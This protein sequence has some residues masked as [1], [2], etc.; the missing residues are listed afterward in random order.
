MESPL[1]AML[2]V[3]DSEVNVQPVCRRTARVAHVAGLCVRLCVAQAPVCVRLCACFRFV[4]CA[5]LPHGLQALALGRGWRRKESW[6]HMVRAHAYPMTQR[7]RRCVS[8]AWFP[9][10]GKE[11]NAKEPHSGW[12]L[13][14]ARDRSAPAA[15]EIWRSTDWPP[16]QP[17]GQVMAAC[18]WPGGGGATSCHA[19]LGPW[20][21]GWV[22]VQ[23]CQFFAVSY[24]I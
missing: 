12:S 22:A 15:K 7:T 24:V 3:L 19:A 20:F 17:S 18:L 8:L 23:E 4:I 11:G 1:R 13:E 10:D 21:D 16:L 14:Q 2:Q 5:F 9:Q 6:P